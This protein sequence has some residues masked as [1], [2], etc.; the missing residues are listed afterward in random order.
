MWTYIIIG[1]AAGFVLLLCFALAVASFSF[2]NFKEKHDQ[3]SKTYSTTGLNVGDFV[4]EVNATTFNGR[5]K[6]ES[7]EEYKDHYSAG[8][9]ALSFNNRNSTSLAAF[10]TAAHELGHARQDFTSKKLRKLWK[11]KRTSRIFGWF[12]MPLLLGGLVL[13]ALTI[14]QVLKQTYLLYVGIGICG[15]ALVLLL[16]SIYLKTSEISIEKEASVFGLEFLKNF[17][18]EK[19]LNACKEFLDSA[20]L[21]YWAM[22]L[23][24]LLGWTFLTNK[25]SMFK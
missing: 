12:F 15:V 20:R 8:R 19:E 14:F 17:L 9:I 24:G 18:S 25:E 16:F 13:S 7:C 11:L 5:L 21:T 3:Y 2:S 6:Q 4:S 22:F 23:R 10:A 1:I